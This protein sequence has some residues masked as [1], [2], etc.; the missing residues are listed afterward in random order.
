MHD[1]QCVHIRI[2]SVFTGQIHVPVLYFCLH[3]IEH[4]P[5][6]ELACRFVHVVPLKVSHRSSLTRNMTFFSIRDAIADD[7]EDIMAL[8]NVSLNVYQ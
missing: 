8:V 2:C 5:G 6:H 3:K 4:L 7:C 1:Q